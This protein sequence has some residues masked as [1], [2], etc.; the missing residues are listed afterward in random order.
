MQVTRNKGR[1]PAGRGAATVSAHLMRIGVVFGLLVVAALAPTDRA[2]HS[3]D[4][5][6]C[7]SCDSESGPLTPMSNGLSYCEQCAH[8][9]RRAIG[10]TSSSCAFGS[11]HVSLE[12]DI[13]ERPGATR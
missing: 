10:P 6:A 4:A 5:A 2:R 11:T 8:S 7:A 12:S 13:T 3:S 9:L 1:G